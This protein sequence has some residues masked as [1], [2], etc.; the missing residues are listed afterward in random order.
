MELYHLRYFI[1]VAEELCFSRAA[2]RLD[3][4]QTLLS[5]QIQNLE[6]EL[7]VRLFYRSKQPMALTLAGAVFCEKARRLLLE[8]ECA[9]A[10]TQRAYS[11]EAGKIT[12]AFTGTAEYDILPSLAGAFHDA[13]PLAELRLLEMNSADQ[14]QALR[15]DRIQVGIL[16]MPPET[17]GFKF[18]VIRSEP[19]VFAMPEGHA[20]AGETGPIRIQA[21]AND[22]FV[23]PAQAAGQGYYDTVQNFFS[24]EGICPRIAREVSDLPAALSLVASGVGVA[25]IPKSLQNVCI[26]GI[27][28]RELRSTA[29]A[30]KTALAWRYDDETPLVR[31]FLATA[32]AALGKKLLK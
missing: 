20:L 2:V 8:L 18:R 11:A 25:L 30:L 14:I 28:Y 4:G 16:C 3:I 26:E 23:L 21:V 19:F 17:A 12:V 6:E 22:S 29:V 7:D 9:C 5:Q 24:M 1:V 27:V 15:A 13:Y 10:E 31:S 32:E